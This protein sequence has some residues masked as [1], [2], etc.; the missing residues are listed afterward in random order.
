MRP[1]GMT[2]SRPAGRTT[3]TALAGTMALLLIALVGCSGTRE[4]AAWND[5]TPA[6]ATAPSG[7]PV[8][9]APGST[10]APTAP[11]P[12]PSKSSTARPGPAPTTARVVLTRSGGIAGVGDTITVEPRGAWTVINRSGKRRTGSLTVAQ[13]SQLRQLTNDPRLADEALKPPGG[14]DCRDVFTYTL[15][16][17]AYRVTFTDCSTDSDRPAAALAIVELLTTATD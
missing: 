16:T 6:G 12:T 8:T 5:G 1:T 15:S 17:G 4:R 10:A 14:T 3:R 9:P 13:R 11:E 7:A 2:T